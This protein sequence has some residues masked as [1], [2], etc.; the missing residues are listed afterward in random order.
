MKVTILIGPPGSGKS[1]YAKENFTPH[2]ICS[3]DDYHMV[4]GQYIFKAENI[5]KAHGE[6][7]LKFITQLRQNKFFGDHNSPT[8]KVV[9]DNTNTKIDQIAPY[10]AIAKAYEAELEI[11]RFGWGLSD[12]ECFK[13]NIHGVPLKTIW[14]MTANIEEMLR[15]WPRH[16]PEVTV[17]PQ[18]PV[19]DELGNPVLE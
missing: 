17:I 10:I 4:D 18:A 3:A 11:K 15:I 16:W 19:I 6:C 14:R 12:E 7:L 13:R 1:T 9:V 2:E 8:N 5:S